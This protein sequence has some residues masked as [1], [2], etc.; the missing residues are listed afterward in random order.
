[1]VESIPVQWVYKTGH[2]AM[3]YPL[4]KEYNCEF[5][6]KN[7]LRIVFAILDKVLLRR[8]WTTKEESLTDETGLLRIAQSYICGLLGKLVLFC[9]TDL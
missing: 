3:R 8:Q 2:F 6:L 5:Y 7:L 9:C 1:M 4:K